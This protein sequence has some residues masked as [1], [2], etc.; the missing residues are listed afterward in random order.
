MADAVVSLAACPLVI[1]AASAGMHNVLVTD[2]AGNAA[3]VPFTIVPVLILSTAAGPVGGRALVA[4]QGFAALSLI[5]IAFGG[6]PVAFCSADAL[7]TLSACAFTVPA[8]VAGAHTI[9]AAAS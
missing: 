4:G 6:M 9:L 5:S 1:P 7:G 3:S 2:S 8:S